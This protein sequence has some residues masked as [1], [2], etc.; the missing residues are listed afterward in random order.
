MKMVVYIRETSS[1]NNEYAVDK[2]NVISC[3]IQSKHL[4]THFFQLVLP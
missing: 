3:D 2:E 4:V 1:I